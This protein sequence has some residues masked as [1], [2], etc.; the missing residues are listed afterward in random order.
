MITPID[1]SVPAPP[2]PSR[3]ILGTRVNAVSMDETIRSILAKAR[4]RQSAVIC[5][6]NVHMLMEAH[7]SSAYRDQL[8]AA[9]L[10]VPDGMPLV[11]LLR[12][13]GSAA[14]ER[15]A[16]PD[17]LPQLC[18]AAAAVGIPVGFLGGREEVLSA[19]IRNLKE[20]AQDLHIAFS[21][22]PPFRPLDATEDEA[23]IERINAS[24]AAILFIALGC[25]R[26]ECWMHEHRS[27]LRAVMIGIGAALDFTAGSVPRAPFWMQ[28]F[29]LEWLFRLGSEPRRL[30]RRYAI[31]NSM[32][33]A[34]IMREMLSARL[35]VKVSLR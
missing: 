33:V 1:L 7:S 34:L 16:G 31:T 14:Q 5:V 24:G 11:W 3:N 4:E 26:Q 35:A 6:A 19:A 29:G 17:L 12:R 25:P 32:F 21:Y 9:D 28:R 10:V 13:L 20:S 30:W 22:A 18:A 27:K 8:N 15:V 2:P 23:L